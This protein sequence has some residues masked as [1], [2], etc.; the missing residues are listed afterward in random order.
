MSELEQS[1]LDSLQKLY[2]ELLAEEGITPALVNFVDL[3]VAY[4]PVLAIRGEQL[5]SEVEVCPSVVAGK[6]IVR[7]PMVNGAVDEHEL[8][9]MRLRLLLL[10]SKE[11]QAWR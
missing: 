4:S 2:W 5:G 10:R 6:W 7:H 3:D 1:A 9:V 11:Q 8:K